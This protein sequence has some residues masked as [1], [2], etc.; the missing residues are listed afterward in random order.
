MLAYIFIEADLPK[1]I[2]NKLMKNNLD[3]TFNSISTDGDTSTSDTL[4]LFSLKQ[5]R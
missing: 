5:L 3:N 2:L 4:I 1:N